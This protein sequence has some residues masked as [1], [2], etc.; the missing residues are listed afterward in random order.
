[1]EIMPEQSDDDD[2][3]LPFAVDEL[4]VR[5]RMVTLGPALT[6]ILDRHDY[7]RPVKALLGEAAALAALLA[8]SLK[9]AGRFILQTRTNGPVTMLVVDIRSPGQM[10]ATATFDAD[11]VAAISAGTNNVGN[12]GGIAE[13]MGKG[14]LAMTIEQGGDLQRYQGHVALDGQSLEE[15]AHAYFEQSEQIPTLIRLA[16][17][18]LYDRASGQTTQ[19]WR[20]GGFMVQFLPESEDRIRHRDLSPGD[21]PAD[22]VMVLV[23]ESDDDDAWTE[24]AALAGTIG[25]DELIDPSIPAERLLYRLFNQR[26]VRVFDPVPLVDRCACT[27]NRIRAVLD[28]MDEADEQGPDETIEVRCEF[29]GK[30]YLFDPLGPQASSR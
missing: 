18:E 8:T 25:D 11:A 21:M 12:K 28:Q 20:A 1:M 5:G 29:C 17:A 15:A 3:V 9:D 19:S 22:A 10:R 16:V 6:T 4:D 30:L 24:A 2:R 7:P 26:G 14:T 13:L 27:R 23:S